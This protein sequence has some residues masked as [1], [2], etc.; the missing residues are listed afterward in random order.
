MSTI[1]KENIQQF[2]DKIDM[3]DFL[4]KKNDSKPPPDS[5]VGDQ[6]TNLKNDLLKY[7]ELI[8]DSLNTYHINIKS[9][10][11]LSD[12]KKYYNSQVDEIKIKTDKIKEKEKLDDRISE[13]Y[14]KDYEFKK[15]IIY[16]LKILYLIFIFITVCVIIYKKKHK[17]KKIYGFLLLLFILPFFLIRKIYN[18]FLNFIGHL[19]IDILYIFFIILISLISFGIYFISR[20]IFV[21]KKTIMESV[22]EKNENII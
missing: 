12:A 13:F 11:N 20:K 3:N 6:I 22:L 15:S 4:N 9:K 1:T 21:T 5:T 17:E 19:S 16:Y 2:I 7:R 8:K 14:G 18:F 10:K